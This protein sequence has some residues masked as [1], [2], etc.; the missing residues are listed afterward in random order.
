M[1]SYISIEEIIKLVRQQYPTQQDLITALTNC[2]NGKWKNKAYFQFVDSK[3]ANQIG[4]E[5]Q[6][7]TNI[8][9]EHPD[10]GT[11]VLD[12]LKNK[13]IGGIEFLEL[14]D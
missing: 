4:A 10:K 12:V 7:D 14:L 1:N 3:N 13:R 6:F 11:I 8:V 5:W 2:E 9:L